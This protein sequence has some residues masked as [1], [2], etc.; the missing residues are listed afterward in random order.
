MTG[1]YKKEEKHEVKTDDEGNITEE[2]HEVK[3][4]E[5]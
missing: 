2:K 3:E 1:E 4:E 5:D